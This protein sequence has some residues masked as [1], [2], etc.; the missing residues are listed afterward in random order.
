MA[1]PQ[2]LRWFLGRWA[3]E[4][5]VLLSGLLSGQ[6]MRTMHW[7]PEATTSHGMAADGIHP[8]ALGYAQWADG[9]CQL[10]LRAG[11]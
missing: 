7:H 8:S 3:L 11:V 4:M 5:N 9:L 6:E 1:L 2:P 10:I